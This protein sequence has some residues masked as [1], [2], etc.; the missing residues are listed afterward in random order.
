M[1]DTDEEENDKLWNQYR[2]HF[3][4]IVAQHLTT[5]FPTF[6]KNL[7]KDKG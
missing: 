7:D 4:D 2:Q 1:P 3:T 6:V 5:F